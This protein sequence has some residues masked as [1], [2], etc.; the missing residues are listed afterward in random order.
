MVINIRL[1][2]LQNQIY[3][4]KSGHSNMVSRLGENPLYN[5]QFN[6]KVVTTIFTQT[7]NIKG[8]LPNTSQATSLANIRQVTWA[9]LG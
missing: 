8:R 1:N 7:T 9:K 3:R 2:G 5:P 6:L 4:L